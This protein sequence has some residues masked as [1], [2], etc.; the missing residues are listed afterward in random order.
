MRARARVRGVRGSL[1][2]AMGAVLA[3]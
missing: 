1:S 2:G 3:W